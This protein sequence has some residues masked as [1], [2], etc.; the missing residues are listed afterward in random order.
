MWEQ[1]PWSSIPPFFLLTELIISSSWLS[2]FLKS[3]CNVVNPMLFCS[4]SSVTVDFGCYWSHAA[5]V[6]NLVLFGSYPWNEDMLFACYVASLVESSIIHIHWSGEF[7]SIFHKVQIWRTLLF[8]ATSDALGSS[9]RKKM[10]Q[11]DNQMWE[12]Q[13][14]SWLRNR[15]KLQQNSSECQGLVWTEFLWQLFYNQAPFSHQL[16]RTGDLTLNNT[17]LQ[18]RTEKGGKQGDGLWGNSVKRRE[19]SSTFSLSEWRAFQHRTPLVG[20]SWDSILLQTTRILFESGRDVGIQIL[21]EKHYVQSLKLGDILGGAKR[22]RIEM[23]GCA[24]FV[25]SLLCDGSGTTTKLTETFVQCRRQVYYC[26]F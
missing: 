26:P 25:L 23:S 20:F 9:A 4:S 16:L 7:C 22:F 2:L 14:C 15:R 24:N 5:N 1:F 21:T 8:L 12:T 11:D 13:I 6:A 17:R 19:E 10:H 3:C 18:M